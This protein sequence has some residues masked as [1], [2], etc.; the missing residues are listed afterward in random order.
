MGGPGSC[1]KKARATATSAF[2][3]STVHLREQDDRRGPLVPNLLNS[4]EFSNGY[5][6]PDLRFDPLSAT[7]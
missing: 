7:I 2:R 3:M 6:E 4:F 1:T 5:G